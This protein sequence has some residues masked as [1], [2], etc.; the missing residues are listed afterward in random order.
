MR[1]VVAGAGEIGEQLVETLSENGE[2]EIVIIDRDEARTDALA[3]AFDTLA[4]CGDATHPKVLE[5]AQ[6]RRADALIA[7]TGVDA[8]NVVIAMLARRFEVEKV[9]V[10]L[11]SNA[12][13]AACEEIGVTGIVTPKLAAVTK[14]QALLA[15]SSEVDFSFLTQGGVSLIELQ[16]GGV[17][18]RPLAD[19]ELPEGALLISIVREDKVVLPRGKTK[20]EEND[21]LL[22]LVESDKVTR[23]L[24]RVLRLA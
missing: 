20:L 4:I 1:I 13:R 19:L 23:S 11:D 2:N 5:K 3:A 17:K 14:L 18:N 7:V 16:T 12:L 22:F 9:I 21:T 6:I 15:G 8:V 24:K 10:K